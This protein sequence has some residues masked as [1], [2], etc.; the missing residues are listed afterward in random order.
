MQK[1]NF[2]PNYEI[3]LTKKQFIS[4]VTKILHKNDNNHIEDFNRELHVDL[5]KLSQYIQF[6]TQI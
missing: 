2:M 4:N 3:K 6:K 1:M 5:E